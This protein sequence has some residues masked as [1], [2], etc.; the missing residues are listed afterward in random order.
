MKKYPYTDSTDMII[1][2]H[3]PKKQKKNRIWVPCLC[4]ALAASLVTIGSIGGGAYY[5]MQSQP[6]T[7]Q[8][9]TSS[10]LSGVTN[11]STFSFGNSEMSVT[12]IAAKVGPS[13]VGVINK[14]KVTPQRYYD[15]FTGRTY[16]TSDPNSDELIEQGSGSGIIISEDG[17]IVTNQHV[18]DG[19]TEISV[20]L[21]TS[22]EY[23]AT[24][25]GADEKSDLAVL[26][27]DKSGLPA[28][29]L[30]DSETVQVG[31]L[32]VAIGNPLGQELAGTVTAGVV[33]AV[34]RT[35]TVDNKTY[36]LIQTDAAINPGNSGGALVNSR[37]EV[38]GINT[39]KLSDTEVE[40]IGFAIAISEAKP[41]IDDLINNGYV[42]GR[43]LV[44]IMVRETNSG[45]LVDSVTEGSGAAQA[46]VQ[47]GDLIVKADGTAITTSAELNE[48]RDKKSPGDYLNLT[49]LRNGEM[50]DI[51]VQLG[52]DVPTDSDN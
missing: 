36:N 40:G 35:M 4:S 14:T 25:V 12:E 37:G 45:L 32:A 27:I 7:P 46:G 29:T 39:I 9:T 33:S 28:A 21:N 3:K 24:L 41:I 11:T 23:T 5:Y 13:C 2:E 47:A 51:N 42:S 44:G 15:P 22:E 52:E 17:Y 1:Y 30:G 50:L 6:E 31:E 16:Y 49:I 8:T 38:I 26:K 18:I 48:I 34:N 20:I 19:A 10:T 43:P